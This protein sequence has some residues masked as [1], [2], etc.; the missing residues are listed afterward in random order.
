MALQDV[1]ENLNTLPFVEYAATILSK[2]FE[3][4]Q[5]NY[6]P[7]KETLVYTCP[8]QDQASLF[9]GSLCPRHF[10]L[11]FVPNFTHK[12]QVQFLCS[13]FQRIPFSFQL[14]CCTNKTTEDELQLYFQRIAFFSDHKYV[15]INANL[16]S[17]NIQEVSTDYEQHLNYY[18]NL[19]NL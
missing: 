12:Q 3:Y 6:V 14:L 4:D 11:H 16:L 1:G 10:I 15:I 5:G 18:L 13:L 17:R 2:L 19:V 9:H 7:K 8:R